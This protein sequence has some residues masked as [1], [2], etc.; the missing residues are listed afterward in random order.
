MKNKYWHALII[1]CLLCISCS[2]TPTLQKL[3]KDSVIL[4]FG[5]S[6]TYGTGTSKEFSY[7][8]VL[9][10]ITNIRVISSGIP[11]EITQKGLPRLKEELL[12]YQ[13]NLV[14]LCHGGND[15]L[16]RKDKQITKSN[17]LKMVETI[18]QSGA[19]VLLVAVPEFGLIPSAADFYD[20]IASEFN[21]PIELDIVPYLERK[22]AYKS[23][24]IHFNREGYAKMATAIAAMLQEHGA[25]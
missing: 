4:A 9:Q 19:D 14:I 20:E 2:D 25:I 10:Q 23:D 5:D 22:Q 24:S 15:I 3:N 21:I 6:L 13:P 1:L 17:L 8:S 12:E 7:P 11:G 16:R 18:K